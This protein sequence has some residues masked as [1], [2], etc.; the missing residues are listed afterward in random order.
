MIA[1]TKVQKSKEKILFLNLLI[2]IKVKTNLKGYSLVLFLLRLLYNL[3]YLTF[4]G[5]SNSNSQFENF[6]ASYQGTI[7][8][9]KV[10]KCFTYT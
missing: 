7:L 5:T 9:Y 8:N 4:Q 6:L 1:Q 3:F 2:S 10:F